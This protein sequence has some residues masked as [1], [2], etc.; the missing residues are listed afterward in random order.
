MCGIAC[1]TRPHADVPGS[2]RALRSLL[3]A[4]L[5][6]LPVVAGA[7]SPPQATAIRIEGEGSRTR[8]SLDLDRP[9]SF[10][11][12]AIQ[13]P[14][15]LVVDMP[16]VVWRLRAD[17]PGKGV[18]AGERHGLFTPTTSRL[19]LD[20]R[21]PFTLV[22]QAVEPP[23]R[24]THTYH[25]V[26]ELET[27]GPPPAAAPPPRAAPPVVAA[28]APPRPL[29]TL[30]VAAPLPAVTPQQAPAT[31]QAAAAPLQTARLIPPAPPR[32]PEP[33][34][35]TTAVEPAPAPPVVAPAAGPVVA[36]SAAPTAGIAATV[37]A[38]A[39]A[40]SGRGGRP[41][42]GAAESA[43]PAAKTDV[44]LVVPPP[45]PQVASPGLPTIVID[46]GHGGVDPGTIGVGGM[47]EK[48]VVLQLARTLR[49][50]LE[51]SG[52]YRAVLTRNDDRFLRLR[53]RIAI[54]RED[55]GDLFISLHANALRLGS[56]RGAAIYT[57]SEDGS[58]DEAERLAS[59]ENKDD[60]LAGTDLS[61]HDAV[62]TS[63]LID[64]AAARD[65]QPLDRLRRAPVRGAGQGDAAVHQS[66]RSGGFAVLKSPDIPSVL[67][68]V[69]YL[70]TPRTRTIC[71]NRAS[72]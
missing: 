42:G 6:A 21:G 26:L 67:I 57:L 62:V 10:R 40:V 49:D 44:A 11:S 25:L 35:A 22:R 27:Q 13:D 30:T 43:A 14:L 16:E 54:A 58:D 70:T 64:L 50:A 53:E 34:P 29:G 33:A 15:R 5:V 24:G 46:P 63:I 36:A 7:A 20:M 48:D 66:Q 65:Q 38:W 17:P 9:V 68:E 61:A 31:L 72:A 47:R 39:R 37:G 60:I 28:G 4:A 55:H 3:A 19:V 56:M 59:K 8:V 32:P 51:A 12:F 2:A 69:G 52:R 1:R 23:A 71:R 18:V 45:P 41:F